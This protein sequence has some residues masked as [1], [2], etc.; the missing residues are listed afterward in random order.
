MI[1]YYLQIRHAHIGTALASGGLFLLRAILVQAGASRWAMAAPVRFLSYGIDTALLTAA[2]M[3]MTITRQ[4]PFARDWL[5]LK[6][7][8][9][10]LYIVLGTFAL[11]R[12][13]TPRI[14]RWCTVG[15]VA[16]FAAILLVARNR[17]LI[18]WEIG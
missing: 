5:T 7:A 13:R 1:E 9:V 8:L 4:Y 10:V 2:L 17:G 16:V 14:R 3:L 12:G 6:L 18:G 11:R 15:A